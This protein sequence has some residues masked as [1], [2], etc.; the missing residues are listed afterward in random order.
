[1]RNL[2]TKFII[3]IY[4]R[5]FQEKITP[6]AQLFIKNLSY[7]TIG[8]G[9][10]AFSIFAFQILGGRILG[11]I[12]YGKYVLVDSLALFLYLFMLLGTNTAIV[13]YVSEESD[14]KKQRKIISTVYLIFISASLLSVI[15]F[16]F[17][18]SQFSKLFSVDLI[19]FRLSI[20][21]ALI[22]SFYI[23]AIDTLR[24]LHEMKRLSIFRACYGVL[25][26][27]IFGFFLVNQYISF[28]SLV[29]S[30]CCAYLIIFIFIVLMLRKYFS[31]Q[32]DK[33]LA[34][35]FLK[36]G[37]FVAIG[38]LCFAFLPSFSK[39]L[40]NKYLS[41]A[42]VGIYNAYYFSSIG[43]IIFL[44]AVFI[45]VF[46][47][48]ISRRKHKKPIFKKIRQLLPYLFL[49]G[50][51]I[52]FA[53]EIIILRLYG[54]EYPLNYLLIFLFAIVGILI[55]VYG[56][57]NW[58]FCSY[59]ISGVK[60]STMVAILTASINILFSLYLIPYIALYGA[61]ISLGIAYFSGIVGLLFFKN[62]ILH[63]SKAKQ[64]INYE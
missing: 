24:G 10:A 39:I 38:S 14:Y 64:N 40:V 52:L 43:V 12:E 60:I 25:A 2:I 51:P 6:N 15:F 37:F 47:P 11:P 5:I 1:M 46:F 33:L 36:Y 16:S 61:I 3:N 17:L 22:Y 54:P 56:L 63:I 58:I 8:Y 55:G 23:M 19:I 53:I 31:F 59:G 27:L 29:F 48:A 21:F 9:V 45:T 42:N 35:K 32:F 34:I 44:S 28:K 49:L 57:Y 26:L 30:I 13:K 41:T 7:I 20:I 50:I 18:S 4:E 62:R